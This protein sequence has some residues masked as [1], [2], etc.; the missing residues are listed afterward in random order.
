MVTVKFFTTL[1]EII[2]KREEKLQNIISVEDM[3]NH[4]SKKYG[5]QFNNYIFN[6][7]G[8]VRTHLIFLVNGQSIKVLQ[9]IKT[10]LCDEDEVAIL[11][12]VGGG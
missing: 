2:G 3:L 6:E 10:K 11:P 9:G 7:R 5:Y 1:R 12:Q 4:L 8:I